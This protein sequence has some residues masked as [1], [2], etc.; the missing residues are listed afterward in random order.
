[1]WNVFYVD[2]VVV[3]FSHIDSLNKTTKLFVRQFLGRYLHKRL[4][5]YIRKVITI[6]LGLSA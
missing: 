6:G 1:M 3:S 5:R 4:Y 2:S